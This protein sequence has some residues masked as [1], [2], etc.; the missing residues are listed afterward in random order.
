M[1]TCNTIDRFCSRVY[2]K[3]FVIFQQLTPYFK[4][5]LLTPFIHIYGVVVAGQY[6]GQQTNCTVLRNYLEFLMNR[7]IYT[8][9]I[10]PYTAKHQQIF[11]CVT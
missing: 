8:Q 2:I 5:Y 7:N 11:Q 4:K 10:F 9:Q 6:I 3:D 1:F